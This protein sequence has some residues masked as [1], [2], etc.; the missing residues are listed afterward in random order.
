MGYPAI[1]PHLP[2]AWTNFVTLRLVVERERVVK[3]A[4]GLSIEEAESEREERREAVS[5]SRF[6]GWINW[7]GADG[8]NEG[9]REGLKGSES[10]PRGMFGF[11]IDGR[12]LEID[13]AG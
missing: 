9:V 10:G 4:P 2:A 6:L 12:G 1:R 13:H 7:W 11:V 8:W 5:K 3:F